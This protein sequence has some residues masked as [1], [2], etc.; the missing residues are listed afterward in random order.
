MAD[1]LSVGRFLY[2]LLFVVHRSEE[3]DATGKMVEEKE[4]CCEWRRAHAR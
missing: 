3:S 1:Y 2:K 4:R